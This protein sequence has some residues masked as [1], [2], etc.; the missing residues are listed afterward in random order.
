[1]SANV[2]QECFGGKQQEAEHKERMKQL[3]NEL[4]RFLENLKK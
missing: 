4:I 3:T 2:G 1:V